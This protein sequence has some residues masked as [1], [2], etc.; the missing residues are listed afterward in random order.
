VRRGRSTRTTT[1]LRDKVI[2]RYRG[3]E[4]NVVVNRPGGRDYKVYVWLDHKPVP[5]ADE[6]DDL[7]YDA[8]GSYFEVTAPRM[9]NVIRGPYGEHELK[10]A[11][12]SREFDLY[13][14]TFSGCPQ[15]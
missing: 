3:T 7:K 12:D 11:S 15:N 1:D 6:G 10:L 13:S 9:Y 5:R 14:Y 4:V 2:I 8:R